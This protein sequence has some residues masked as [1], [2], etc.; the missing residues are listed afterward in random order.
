MRDYS[1]YH[2]INLNEKIT[3]DGLLLLEQSL[4]G[5]ESREALINDITPSRLLVY[6]KWDA[7]SS[8]KKIVGQIKDVEIGNMI[9]MDNNTWLVTTFPE[10]NKIYRKAE[11][12]LCNTRFPIKT[13]QKKI[14]VGKNPNG[15][16]IYDYETIIT[17]I[18][19]VF[20][21]N[22]YTI[23][24]NSSVPLPESNVIIYIPYNKSDELPKRNSAISIRDNQYSIMDYI[25]KKVIEFNDGIERG[26]LEIKLQRVQQGGG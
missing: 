11:I 17:T 5:F 7:D 14:I 15:S 24:N 20:K 1:N 25:Y 13:E 2:N 10:D 4:N 9:V 16:P 19:C 26:C 22:N 21:E 8:S 23:I 3:H 6:Q 18:P 12:E